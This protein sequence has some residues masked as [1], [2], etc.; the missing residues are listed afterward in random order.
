[1]VA[2]HNRRL[3]DK[4]LFPGVL[5]TDK[6]FHAL[7][8]QYEAELKAEGVGFPDIIFTLSKMMSAYQATQPS[9]R[10]RQEIMARIRPPQKVPKGPFTEEELEW[11][12]QHLDR[13]N[14][15]I[16]AAIVEKLSKMRP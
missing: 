12:V 11:L 10:E 8:A 16:G 6:E 14:D 1:M 9:M 15:P 2:L 4:D 13:T 7:R 3:S 5:W